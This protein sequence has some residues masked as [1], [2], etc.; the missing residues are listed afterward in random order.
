VFERSLQT[1]GAPFMSAAQFSGTVAGVS[2]PGA[3]PSVSIGSASVGAGGS[4]AGAMSAGKAYF[5]EIVSGVHAGQRLEVDEAGST[6]TTVALDAASTLNTLGVG[7]LPATLAGARA[8]LREHGTIGAAF[9]PVRFNSTT[10]PSTADRLLLFNRTSNTYTTYWLFR[11]S[12]APKWVRN[13]DATLADAGGRVLAPGEGVLVQ[14]KYAVLSTV[15]TGEVRSWA[16]AS[17]LG[18]GTQMMGNPWPVGQSPAQRVMNSGSGFKGAS[19]ASSAD[20]VR[21]WLGDSVAGQQG[22]TTYYYFKT[23][24]YDQWTRQGDATLANQ[25]ASV[26]FKAQGAAFIRS[27][28]GNP[29]WVIPCPWTP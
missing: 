29:T 18:A 2:G 13:G 14:A 25:G 24:T 4:I 23:G 15:Y 19:L 1:F 21:L 8:E 11:N 20:Q 12:G 9:D 27:V 17:P 28:L 3:A 5:L 26:L 7:Q 16:F 6:A 10:S 22:Y